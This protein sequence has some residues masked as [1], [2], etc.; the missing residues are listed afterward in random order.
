MKRKFG[1]Y[2]INVENKKITRNNDGT[3]TLEA[4]LSGCIEIGLEIDRMTWREDWFLQLFFKEEYNNY[5]LIDLE[6][7]DQWTQN[8]DFCEINKVRAIV[9]KRATRL[10]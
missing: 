7:N 5:R 6:N 1:S 2:T 4:T 8:P 10:W 9:Q 3:L